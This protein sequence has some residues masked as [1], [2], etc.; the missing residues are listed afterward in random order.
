MQ[1]GPPYAGFLKRLIAT[2]IDILIISAVCLPVLWAVYGGG[3]FTRTQPFLE[4]AMRTGAIDPSKFPPVFAGP[5]DVIIQVVLP[6]IAVLIFWRYRSATPGKML[7]R[8]RIVDAATL[9][10]PTTGQWVIRFFA[11]LVSMIPFFLGFLWIAFDK[12]KQGWHD[13]LARTVVLVDT[14]MRHPR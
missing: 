10:R 4:D 1:A 5:A 11:Y 3:Y 14:D 7:L 8:L 2:C 9:G 6:A 13:K 12:K